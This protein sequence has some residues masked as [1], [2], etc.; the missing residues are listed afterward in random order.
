MGINNKTLE[1]C[2][3]YEWIRDRYA[4]QSEEESFLF[5]DAL[6][7]FLGDQFD[8][9]RARGQRSTCAGWSGFNLGV[10]IGPVLSFDRLDAEQIEFV[11][12]GIEYAE[13]RVRY[14]RYHNNREEFGR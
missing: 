12:Q 1:I 11:Q 3:N 9:I 14:F 7:E 5:F 4:L 8:L 10:K 13:D 6:W 2:E